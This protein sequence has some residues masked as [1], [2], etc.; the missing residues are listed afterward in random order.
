MKEDLPR[1]R[2]ANPSINVY[3]DKKPKT[4]EET[5]NPE[6]VVEL[7]AQ[8]T[9]SHSSFLFNVPADNGGVHRL[10]MGGKWSTTIFSELMDV[11]A[12]PWWRKWKASMPPP[13]TIEPAP[14]PR[15][16]TGAAAVLP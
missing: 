12:G 8:L 16:T 6:M 4:K 15:A 9:L 3:V 13:P 5:W 1:I 7:R 11:S 2:Y 10:N 14:K